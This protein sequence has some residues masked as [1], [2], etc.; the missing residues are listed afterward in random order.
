MKNT[1]DKNS[2][3]HSFHVGDKVMLWKPYKIS[4]ISRCFQP[5][6]DGPWAIIEFTGNTNC[7]IKKDNQELNV[8]L[9][10]LKHCSQ[11]DPSLHYT[12][13]QLSTPPNSTFNHYLDDFLDDDNDV[14]VRD[15]QPVI[16]NGLRDP[17]IDLDETHPYNLDISD[18]VDVGGVDTRN[19]VQINESYVAVD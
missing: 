17:E 16:E 14:A 2:K 1:Y 7:R 11:R 18:N 10:Q 12:E 19:N 9:N 5:T 13:T 15:N 6:W 4:G 3:G 8:H